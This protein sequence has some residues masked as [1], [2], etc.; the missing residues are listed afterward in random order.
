MKILR[1]DPVKS[2]GGS[3][4][5]AVRHEEE[6]QQSLRAS[7][8]AEGQVPV[9]LCGGVEAEELAETKL[10]RIQGSALRWP[11]SYGERMRALTASTMKRRK[12][13]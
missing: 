7:D 5:D 9:R 10:H 2:C 12:T 8:G 11:F 6:R 13:G 1:A 3:R 4:A